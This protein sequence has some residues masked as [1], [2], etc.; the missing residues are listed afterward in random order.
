[1]TTRDILVIP[2]ETLR[3]TSEP[4]ADISDYVRALAADM[5]ETMYTA[6]GIGLAAIQ[7]GVPRRII[8][9]DVSQIDGVRQPRVFV[10]P[11]IITAADE[12][13]TR[14]EG[15]L[16]IPDYYEEVTRPAAVR[17]RY[18]DLDGDEREID[19]EGLLATCIQHE[20]DHLNGV[21]FIDHL[22]RLKRE[23][24]EKRFAKQARL[25]KEPAADAYAIDPAPQSATPGVLADIP[26]G[27]PGV[28]PTH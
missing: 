24:V 25:G 13:F 10:N 9:M 28:R 15:C 27:R 1:M 4:V 11:Q 17:V 3:R 8:T 7:I 26:A 20:I 16:S 21:L 18:L 2:H 12:T 6:P 5:F 22:S 14:E 19:A 23:R